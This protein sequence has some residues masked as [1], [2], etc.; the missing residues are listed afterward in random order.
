MNKTKIEWCDYT[1]NPVTGCLHGCEYCYAK[2]IVERFGVKTDGVW[3]EWHDLHT[4]FYKMNGRLNL[5]PYGFEPT[6]HRYRLDEPKKNKKP[7]K[8]FV[9]SM[10]DLF[11]DWV[12]DEWIKEI[13][14]IVTECP[15]HIFM[16]LTKNPKRYYSFEFPDNSWIGAS[17]VNRPDE[18]IIFNND[19]S[20][21][22]TTAHVV[23]DNMSFFNHSFISFEPL[24]NNVMQDCDIDDIDWIIIG[25]QTGP[26]AIKP[27]REWVQAI[28]D[29]ARAVNIPVF[30]KNNLKSIWQGELIQEWPK[31]MNKV[32]GGIR[33]Y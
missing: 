28:I 29:D 20:F 23:C 5:Y 17:A 31:E 9:C 11:G 12:P 15:Q 7:S 4:P 2:R 10:A 16:F 8:I 22:T 26:G 19:G 21:V 1:W 33:G 27:K 30:M 3:D 6:F 24:L 25:A 14:Q 18:K 13:L 32:F